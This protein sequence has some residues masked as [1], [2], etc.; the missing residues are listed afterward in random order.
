MTHEGKKTGRQGRSFSN[1][2]HGSGLVR[3]SEPVAE[4]WPDLCEVVGGAE[5]G[6]ILSAHGAEVRLG[7]GIPHYT[8][9]FLNDLIELFQFAA[10]GVGF[11][12][13]DR[14]SKHVE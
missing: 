2:S 9:E 4:E 1:P 11:L 8:A 13:L 10:K 5:S 12:L 7:L 14:T 6:E 3:R